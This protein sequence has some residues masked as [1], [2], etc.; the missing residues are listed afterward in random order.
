[1]I[2]NLI[3][4]D[5]LAQYFPLR[6]IQYLLLGNH[7][8]QIIFH[9]FLRNF[10]RHDG[11][12][13]TDYQWVWLVLLISYSYIIYSY[14]FTDIVQRDHSESSRMWIPLDI[15]L[16]FGIAIYQFIYVCKHRG[17]QDEP[18][19]SDGPEHALMPDASEDKDQH[20]G[21]SCSEP[22][23]KCHLYED[24]SDPNLKNAFKLEPDSTSM[25]FAAFLKGEN[26]FSMT[27]EQRS[28]IFMNCM[29]V[30]L[31]QIFMIVCI[32]KYAAYNSKFLSSYPADPLILIARFVASLFMHVRLQPLERLGLS[33]MK[34]AVNHHEK[35]HNPV[36]A[37]MFGF[38]SLM[39]NYFVEVTVIIILTGQMDVIGVCFSYTSFFPITNITLFYYD[40]L[41][42]HTI[43]GCDNLQLKFTK[44]RKD[45][46]L[47]GAAWD[48]K[49]M[50]VVYKLCRMMHTTLIYYFMPFSVIFMNF[51][52]MIADKS[53]N[54]FF[55][56]DGCGK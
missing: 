45:S 43:T 54:C 11:K 21:G 53:Y 46:P 19:G 14:F 37:F 16:T 39:I 52:F 35:F 40:T 30:H 1:M 50:R 3:Y 55:S 27:Y 18:A 36:A 44:F 4:K 12:L 10:F 23:E 22:T 13:N 8:L 56:V 20:E 38:V 28:E 26:D 34:Y 6:F 25:G 47:K 41:H 48:I 9:V 33:M 51:R 7:L 42:N 2:D 15:L 17:H 31:S 29:A 32:W 49:L 24:G 5:Q